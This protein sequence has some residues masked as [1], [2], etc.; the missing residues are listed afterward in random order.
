M[1]FSTLSTIS[2]LA[3]YNK[4]NVPRNLQYISSTDTTITFSF[5]PPTGTPTSYTPYV[6]GSVATG[7]GTPSSY[8]VN[9]ASAGTYSIS[10]SATYAT[11][12]TS[13]SVNNCVLWLDAAD[14]ATVVQ[15]SNA[16]SQW[17]DKSSSGYSVIQPTA[18]Y[19]PTYATNLLN[20]KAGIQLSTNLKYLYK[21]GSDIPNFSSATSISVFIVAK[22]DSSAP[23]GGFDLLNTMWFTST[24]GQISGSTTSR[25]HF[26]F[27]D[28]ASQGVTLYLNNSLN[29]SA[30]TLT[31]P[32]NGNAVVGF[33]T[34]ASSTVLSLNGNTVSSGGVTLTSANNS[35]TAFILG[36]ARGAT[37]MYNK[38]ITIYEYLGY[39]S[40]LS[41]TDRQKIEGYL[42][43]KWGLQTKL[44]SSHPY[45][46]ASPYGS[47]TT[48]QSN[49]V[50]MTAVVQ[51]FLYYKFDSADRSNLTVKNYGTG[52]Y[53]LT[54][55]STAGITQTTSKFGDSSLWIP[56]SAY[57]ATYTTSL[58]LPIAITGNG[59]SVCFWGNLS[60]SMSQ[61]GL[62]SYMGW[63]TGGVVDTQM[64]IQVIGASSNKL[65]I[66][67]TPNGATNSLYF[68]TYTKP[69]GNFL[70][71]TWHHICLTI[72][73]T[74][75]TTIQGNIYVDG[76][77]VVS[78]SNIPNAAQFTITLIEIGH[79]TDGKDQ[80]IN[81]YIDDFRLYKVP[82][83]STQ[84]QAIYNGTM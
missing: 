70:D 51:P 63:A 53:D 60:S 62:Y 77:S 42:S 74:N 30:S 26:S 29:N 80:Y 36:D 78:Q 19:Q 11:S 13:T 23:S 66:F 67:F 52:L 21:L 41:T 57:F 9:V 46:S 5:T 12:F 58:T 79:R 33:T 84:V 82:L 7:S 35:N 8:T 49:A 31:T 27:N 81:G 59:Y 72:Q 32:Y 43:W 14:S 39:S 65:Q 64:H 10:I 69:S 18:A 40:Q 38:D 50:S 16:V 47:T 48:A 73:Y 75:S 61:G 3:P 37:N 22:N 45:Y 34:S 6:N 54:I 2:R 71:D 1:A 76:V 17:N 56:S 4:L 20:G 44:P 25:Y 15:S 24:G 55:T 68:T 83:T 28:S